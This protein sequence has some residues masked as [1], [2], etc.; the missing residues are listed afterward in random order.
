ML[1]ISIRLRPNYLPLKMQGYAIM[2]SI[3]QFIIISDHKLIKNF[4]FNSQGFT[5]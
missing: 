2:H 3:A 5:K 4:R 1:L